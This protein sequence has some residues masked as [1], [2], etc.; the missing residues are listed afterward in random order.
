VTFGAREI[1]SNL[2]FVSRSA[3]V[4]TRKEPRYDLSLPVSLRL[5]NSPSGDLTGV[6]E[7]I[8]VHGVLLSTQSPICEGT[9]VELIVTFA[10]VTSSRTVRFAASGRVLRLEQR[11]TGTFAVAVSCAEHP[12][13]L[14]RTE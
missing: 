1:G 12:F 10:P 13:T 7:N 6:S 2:R 14:S 5:S 9:E 3:Q 4:I 8:S 11:K